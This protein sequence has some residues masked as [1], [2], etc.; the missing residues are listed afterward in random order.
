MNWRDLHAVEPDF[1]AEP[2]GAERRA[3]PVVLDEADV[4]QRAGR[5]RSVREAAE[6]EVLDVGRRRL[7]DHLELVVVLQAVRVLAVAA[8]LG[9]ARRL[10]IGRVP[11]LG[12]ER[13]QGSR[14]MEGAGAD[15]DVIGLQDDAALLRPVSSGASRSGTERT[16]EAWPP[17]PLRGREITRRAAPYVPLPDGQDVGA[18]SPSMALRTSSVR[19]ARI[20]SIA[21]PPASKA[22]LEYNQ[23]RISSG[24]YKSAI[25]STTDRRS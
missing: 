21:V 13:A 8:I 19:P 3:F 15:L 2:P 23:V 4:V 20:S 5:C 6:I 9:P 25:R 17:W 16:C 24:V 22:F 11:R 1:P 18:D 12:P 14:G 10:D 7:H